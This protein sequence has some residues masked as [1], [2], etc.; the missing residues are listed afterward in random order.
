MNRPTE[1][2]ENVLR[3]AAKRLADDY[4]KEFDPRDIF[5]ALKS[6]ISL[7]GYEL[8]KE[9]E[10]LGYDVDARIV[11]ALDNVCHLIGEEKDRAV[12]EWVKKENI[13]LAFESGA[14]V[15]AKV[16]FETVEGEVIKRGDFSAS[17]RE[18]LLLSMTEGSMENDFHTD[19][20]V[21]SPIPT[22]RGNSCWRCRYYIHRLVSCSLGSRRS[23]YNNFCGH[24]AVEAEKLLDDPGKYIGQEDSTPDWC[25]F[26]MED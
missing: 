8:G 7:D 4:V 12:A 23:I 17:F 13:T 2:D 5:R 15:K 25:P 6:G 16:G 3:R 21:Q 14:T 19:G 22:R 18:R 10:Q 24:P 9:L 20:S 1:Q 11:E 26:L